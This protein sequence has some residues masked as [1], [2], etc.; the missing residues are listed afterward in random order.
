MNVKSKIRIDSNMVSRSLL[1][2][3]CA[4]LT[5]SI[6]TTI[7][8]TNFHYIAI[9]VFAIFYFIFYALFATPIQFKLN[10]NPKKYHIIN[11]I[12]YAIGAFIASAIA[13]IVLFGENPL[14]SIGFYITAMLAALVFWVFDSIFLQTTKR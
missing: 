14:I 4:A 7:A 1:C 6:I 10:Q 3:I 13:I 8:T 2:S 11:F 5:L 9:I 12:V